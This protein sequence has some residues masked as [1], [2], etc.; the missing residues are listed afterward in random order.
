MTI[1]CFWVD[2]AELVELALR[3]YVSVA[4]EDRRKCESKW[5]YHNAEVPIGRVLGERD[6]DGYLRATDSGKG[7]YADD[8]RWPVSCAFCD[9]YFADDDEWQVFRSRVYRER[10]GEREWSE[11]SLPP[12]AMLDGFWH[13]QKGADGVA[14]VV[15][16]PPQAEDTRGHWWHVDGPSR[17]NGKAGPDWSRTG[18]PR[19]NPPT[20]AASPSILTPDYHGF[21]QLAEGRSV[22]TGD[23]D[24]RS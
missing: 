19:A 21:L 3:R 10:Y 6:E 13:P 11:R 7:E 2:E 8:P 16:L 5:G 14:L 22:L 15:V 17:N 9:Y 12:G 18:D 1:A 4:N 24:G 20:V 23:L